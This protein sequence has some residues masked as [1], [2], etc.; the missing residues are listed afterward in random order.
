MHDGVGLRDMAQPQTE[1]DERMA[2]RQRRIVIGGAPVGNAPA[3]GWQCREHIP[4][5]GGAEAE[6]A[7]ADIRIGFG[8]APCRFDAGRD[9]GRKLAEQAAIVVQRKPWLRRC[10]PRPPRAAPA[11]FAERQ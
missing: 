3:I 5:L 6:D 2:R 1:G 4:E 9:F 10:P 8:L 7:V 11:N